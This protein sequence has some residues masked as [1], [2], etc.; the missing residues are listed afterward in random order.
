M[1]LLGR[2]SNHD[3]YIND[4]EEDIKSLRT[5]LRELEPISQ[6]VKR[7]V[8]HDEGTSRDM[9]R[10]NE[11]IQKIQGDVV[12][13]LKD[14]EELIASGKRCATRGP[15]EI[16]VGDTVGLDSMVEKVWESIQDENVG[17]V[18]LHGMGGC[19]KT[20]LLKKINNEF[21]KRQHNFDA[22]MFVVVSKDYDNH[23]IMNEVR[24]SLNISDDVWNKENE[25]GR[26]RTISRV[27]GQKRFVLLLDDVWE[28][29]KLETMGVP[30][31]S[32]KNN[33]SK[34][35]FTTR[36]ADVCDKML[37]QRNLKVQLL[38]TRDAFHL[39]RQHIGEETLNSHPQTPRIAEEIVLK[40]KGLPLALT[41]VASAMS[42]KKSIRDWEDARNK[43]SNSPWTGLNLERDV[44]SSLKFSYD[45]LPDEMHKKCFLYCAMYPNDHGIYVPTLVDRW[46]GEGFL[47]IDRSIHD[48]YDLGESVINKLKLSG[49]LEADT[50]PEKGSNVKMHDAIRDMALWIA[51]DQNQS[52]YKVLVQRDASTAWRLDAEKRKEVERILLDGRNNEGWQ[53]PDCPNLVTLIVGNCKNLTGISNFL[54]MTNLKVLDLQ[55]NKWLV[56]IP[57]EIGAMVHLE[58]LNLSFT[59]IDRLPI[60]LMNLTKMKVLLVDY[61]KLQLDDRVTLEVISS[62]VRLKVFPC[63]RRHGTQAMDEN[64]ILERLQALLDLEELHIHIQT[65]DGAEKLVRFSRFLHCTR[66]LEL[67][68]IREPMGM[69]L[70]LSHMTAMEHMESL[71]LDS[72]IIVEDSSINGSYHFPKL[73]SVQVLNCHYI[74]HL[75]WLKY[76][77]ALDFLMLIN[78]LALEEIINGPL[79]GQY[80]SQSD[81]LSRLRSVIFLELPKLRSIH[82]RA[83]PFPSLRIMTIQYCPKLR[84][85]PFDQNSAKDSLEEIAGERSWWN[86]LEWENPALKDTF[87]PK[88]RAILCILKL[89]STCFEE[90][91][92]VPCFHSISEFRVQKWAVANKGLDT[93]L[94][95]LPNR[96]CVLWIGFSDLETLLV[97]SLNQDDLNVALWLFSYGLGFLNWL[98]FSAFL[99]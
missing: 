75:T 18:G 87:L 17:I 49:L 52:R 81:P 24:K 25:A 90:S 93:V 23:K 61:V 89:A 13:T 30:I 98:A 96:G 41:T 37:A 95:L 38:T 85:L 58:F 82:R 26:R 64:A 16:P 1:A 83:L 22:I 2:G 10:A 84:R 3:A 70:L 97:V 33:Q 51:H 4:L 45:R 63:S 5:K 47:G 72:L 31:S 9:E 35:L 32:G 74:T 28:K 14:V 78:C 80:L 6:D 86:N 76:A 77:P 12:K 21:G 56:E 34:I 79:E 91:M 55:S 62:F 48:M 7:R 19:G 50:Y 40:C 54:H 92:C 65:I 11:A 36:I 67:D 69:S 57:R 15:V 8:E 66:R 99:C 43:L 27:L 44:F 46:I 60:D 42:G 29:L 68:T 94:T 53:V 71:Y 88:F 20:I 73:K 39:F 59:E